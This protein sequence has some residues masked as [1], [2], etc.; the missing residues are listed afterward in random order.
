MPVVVIAAL[1]TGS[2][3]VRAG[4]TQDGDTLTILGRNVD[5]TLYI[6][7]VEGAPGSVTVQLNDDDLSLYAGVAHISIDLNSGDNYAEILQINIAGNLTIVSEGDSNDAFIGSEDYD[8]NFIGGDLLVSIGDTGDVVDVR[9]TWIFGDAT[10]EAGNCLLRLGRRNESGDPSLVVL[11]NLAVNLESTIAFASRVWAGGDT[12]IVGSSF[13]EGI[14]LGGDAA[15]CVFAG[16]LLVDLG[17]GIDSMQF[18]SSV[19][20]GN[21]SLQ[22][23]KSADWL[24][25]GFVNEFLG[26]FAADGG[27]GTDILL[28]D[29][30]DVFHRRP[31]FKSFELFSDP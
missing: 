8:P 2:S 30:D 3:P 23:G 21:T 11:G 5:D 10:V 15:G 17:G 6:I 12:E 28:V 24:A 26:S 27:P 1:W 14:S 13:A 16:N 9:E 31:Q 22:L 29:P 20:Q 7:G 18:V 19:V 25:F 4:V